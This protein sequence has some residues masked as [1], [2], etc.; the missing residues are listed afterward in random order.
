[1]L[2]PHQL[3]SQP[4]PVYSQSDASILDADLSG[5]SVAMNAW[6]GLLLLIPLLVV[7][8]KGIVERE[9]QYL[10]RKFGQDYLSYKAQVRRWL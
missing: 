8:Q 4:L 1:M 6:W 2:F 3:L 5:V 9:E 10:I 7:V